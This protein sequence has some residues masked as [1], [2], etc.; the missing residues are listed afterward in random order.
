MCCDEDD[1]GAQLSFAEFVSLLKRRPHEPCESELRFLSQAEYDSAF[2]AVVERY[3]RTIRRYIARIIDD[4]EIEAMEVAADLTQNVFISLY[5]TRNSFDPPYIYR[6][7][8]N[9]ALDELRRRCREMR[10][11]RRYWRGIEV[12]KEDK[13]EAPD[14]QP[15]P[16]EVLIFWRREAAIKN[17]VV[18][19]PE[20]FRVPLMLF[21][22]GR[23]Y[24][25][26]I[27]LTGLNEGTVK[28]RICRA[29]RLL[30]RK[31]HA[32]L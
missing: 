20:H 24:Q 12:R 5:R 31:L 7:A 22:Q 29:K 1:P 32:Y 21:A 2:D 8:K 18:M 11:L 3:S 26:I 9:E 14:Q 19:L 6:A 25:Q 4:G 27:E 10:A 28:S 17:A 23:S 13:F 16:D 15:L 30:R